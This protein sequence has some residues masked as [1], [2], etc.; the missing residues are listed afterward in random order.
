M[1]SHPDISNHLADAR[2]EEV[3]R[4]SQLL[5]A[6]QQYWAGEITSDEFAGFVCRY[7]AAAHARKMLLAEAGSTTNTNLN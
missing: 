5:V 2:D 4:G 7:G 1:R 3:R 6:A